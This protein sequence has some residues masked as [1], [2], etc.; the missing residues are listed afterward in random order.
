MSIKYGKIKFRLGRGRE[1]GL[2]DRQAKHETNTMEIGI[3]STFVKYQFEIL[4]LYMLL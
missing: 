3:K 1:G 4:Y 2:S